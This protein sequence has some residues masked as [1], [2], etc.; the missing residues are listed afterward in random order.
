MKKLTYRGFFIFF[1]LCFQIY[2]SQ[3]TQKYVELELKNGSEAAQKI[4]VDKFYYDPL[5]NWSPFGNDT[6]SDTYY[7]YTDWKKEHPHES[8]RMFVNDELVDLGYP[9]FDLNLD[10]SDPEKLK[11]VVDSMV[12]QYLGLNSINN[13]IISLA[14]AQLFLE[15]RIEP[16]VKKWA[17]A[18]FSRES[19]YHDFWD[20]EGSQ[21]ERK[22]RMEKLQNDLRKAK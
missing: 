6:G 11:N 8:I 3:A 12:N 1:I 13:S 4:M 20:D 14:F 15:G 22:A 21:G 17:E 2:Q 19:A 9:N 16:E 10:G 5:D 18:A 7:L